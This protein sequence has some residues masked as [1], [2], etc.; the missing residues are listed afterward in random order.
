MKVQRHVT[1]RSSN[2]LYTEE[3]EFAQIDILNSHTFC[4]K[5]TGHWAIKQ[6]LF[7]IYPNLFFAFKVGPS[8]NNTLINVYLEMVIRILEREKSRPESY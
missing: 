5:S 1:N 7:I 8:R 2:K 3:K 6:K 4:Q